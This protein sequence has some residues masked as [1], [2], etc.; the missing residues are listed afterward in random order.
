M[1]VD[2][3]P[4]IKERVKSL[5]ITDF[6]IKPK[7]VYLNGQSL[8]IQAGNDIY[9]LTSK[10]LPEQFSI[11]DNYTLYPEAETVKHQSYSAYGIKEFTESIFI[12]NPIGESEVI[13]FLVV[14]PNY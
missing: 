6:T 10:I 5:G 13:E 7:L 12:N 9:F 14:T 11:E 1:Q 4:Y 8:T 3:I 2:I